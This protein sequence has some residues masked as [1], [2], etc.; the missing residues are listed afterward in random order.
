MYN[1]T[2]YIPRINTR[3]NNGIDIM[4]TV[5]TV[6]PH[7]T[8]VTLLGNMINSFI[9]GSNVQIQHQGDITYVGMYLIA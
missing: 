7:T 2:I 9:A 4:V 5:I 3:I 6:L 8:L 1:L